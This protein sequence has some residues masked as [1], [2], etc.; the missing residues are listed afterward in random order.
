MSNTTTRQKHAV[1]SDN[2][3]SVTSKIAADTSKM[4]AIETNDV[5]HYWVHTNRR[6]VLYSMICFGYFCNVSIFFDLLIKAQIN[7]TVN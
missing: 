2:K 7:F 1:V 3:V 6:Y 5:I 4:E